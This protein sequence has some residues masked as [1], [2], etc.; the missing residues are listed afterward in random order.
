MK[1]LIM[2]AGGHGR[3]VLDILKAARTTDIIGFLDSSK[4]LHGQKI[5]GVEVLGDISMLQ[6]LINKKDAKSIILAVG[7]NEERKKLYEKV[8]KLD[9]ELIN[10]IHPSAAIAENVKLGRG[11]VIAR[12]A[13]ICTDAEIGDNSIINTGAIVEH[14]DKI[15]KHVHISPGVNLAGGEAVGD[16][17]FIGIGST[18]IQRVSIGEGATVGA[19]SVVLED[20]PPN[21]TAVGSPARIVK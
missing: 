4:E 14:Q 18:V 3:V 20:V 21:S 1:T 5:G 15:G 10:A 8:K 9:I 7:D 12:N 17:A 13:T 11:L 16:G 6:E 19:A 2:G